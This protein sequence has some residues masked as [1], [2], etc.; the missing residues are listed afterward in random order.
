MFV[1]SCK[2]HQIDIALLNETNIKWTPASRDQMEHKCKEIGRETWTKGTDSKEWEV[3]NNAYFPGGV[4]TMIT[5]KCRVQTKEK[6]VECGPLGNWIAAKLCH[7]KKTIALMN[8]HRMP[9]SSQHGLHCSLTQHNLVTKDAKNPTCYRKD[10]LN[11]IK[12]HVERNE[13]VDDIT[14]AG[15]LNQD[16]ISTEMYRFFNE[17]GLSDIHSRTNKIEFENMST[18]KKNGSKPIDTIAATEGVMEHVDGC[19]LLSHAEV[20]IS[21]HRPCIIYVNLEEYFNDCFSLWDQIDKVKLNPSRRSHKEKFCEALE[22]QLDVCQLE[23]KIN[24]IAQNPT[25]EEIECIDKAIAKMLNTATKIVEGINR[26][27]HILQKKQEYETLS[28]T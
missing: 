25:I 3:T 12:Q 15:D 23:N 21:D 14:F 24:H 2:Q 13:D 17:I 9:A 7:K 16:V 4:M 27:S 18:S 11:Q 26:K 8:V 22:E 5:G 19:K 10:M 20:V 28:C 6:N 1:T